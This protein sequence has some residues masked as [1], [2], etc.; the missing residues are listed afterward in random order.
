MKKNRPDDIRIAAVYLAQTHVM[1]PDQPYFRLTGN[2]DALLKVHV[3]SASGATAPP[4]QAVVR[5]KGETAILTLLGP[6][7]LPKIL[8]SEPGVVQ[9]RFEDSFVIQ[10]PARLVRPGLSVEVRAGSQTVRHEL[11]VGAPTLVKMKMFDIHY[12]GRKGNDYPEG[13]FKELEA[14]WPVSGLEIERVRNINFPELVIPGRPAAGVAAV[15]VSSPED[16]LAK[17]GKKFDGE[18][19]AALQWVGALSRAGGSQD[20]AM[21]YV[22]IMGVP[23]GGQAG[24]YNGVGSPSVGI[25][26]HELGHAF[27]LP[28]IGE[29]KDYPYRGAM[30]GIPPPK[31]FNEVHV[32]PTWGFDLPSKTFLP[33]T[34]QQSSGR[35]VAGTYKADPMQGGGSGDQEKP[36]R[37]RHFSDYNV[38]KMQ[39]YLERKV[40]V[41]RAG[42]YFKWDDATGDYTKKV[43]ADGV[44]YPTEHEVAVISVMASISLATPDVNL[45]YPP[46]GPY[47][48]NQIRTF[49]P[50]VPADRE[51]ARAAFSPKGGCDFTLKVT[52]GGKERL[53]LLPVSGAEG[54]DPNKPLGLA[55]AAVNLRAEDGPVTAMDLLH[56][57]GADRSGV[58]ENPKVLAQWIK[59]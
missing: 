35:W 21:S 25:M 45:V 8:P 2:R 4:V 26:N 11:A 32:G 48:G 1:K 51:A 31:V 34:V 37:L 56:T 40:A 50:R 43:Q 15:K 22:T 33:P 10:I 23:A 55:T 13:F 7:T 54:A 19:A 5:N 53:Y 30:H 42:Q 16:Y 24:G 38:F 27:S 58:P 57:P 46:V 14:K 28:H 44:H 20:V 12:F 6:A 52:Q 29:Q 18:Q 39:A 3:V 49:D 47:K 36:F 59:K 17:T 9:H 41:F